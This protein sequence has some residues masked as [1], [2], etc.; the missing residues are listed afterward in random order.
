MI[1]IMINRPRRGMIILVAD[2]AA[3]SIN[4]T[5]P[6]DQYAPMAVSQRL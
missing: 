1:T 3:G 6:A 5:H 2:D 4:Y